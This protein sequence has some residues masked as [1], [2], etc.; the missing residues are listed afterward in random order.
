MRIFSVLIILA[1]LMSPYSSASELKWPK[2]DEKWGLSL[3]MFE[4]AQ[5]YYRHNLEKIKNPRYV[6]VVNYAL[7]SNQRRFVL[8]DLKEGKVETY[9]TAHGKGSDPK[10]KGY[11]THFSN[12]EGSKMTSLGFYLT[13]GTY[14]GMHGHSLKL[15]GLEESNSRALERAIVIHPAKYVQEKNNHAGRSW[16]CP[17]LDPKIAPKVIARIKGGSLLLLDK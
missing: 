17:S 15:Q 16:G 5:T 4:K 12:D 8:F 9:L 7:K 11:A 1:A 6:T 2:F 14:T 3:K 13:L 10:N